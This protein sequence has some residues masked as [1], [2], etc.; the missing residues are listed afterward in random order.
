MRNIE[1]FV[2]RII[3]GDCIEVLKML[4]DASVDFVATDPPY[5]VRYESRDGRRIANDENG[6]WLIPAFADL[7]RAL[8]DDRF[9]VSF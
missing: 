5:L 2:N 3:E 7:Y 8:K 4:P 6:D 1:D 9:L